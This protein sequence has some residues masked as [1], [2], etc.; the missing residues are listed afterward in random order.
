MIYTAKVI[1]NGGSQAIRLPKE[2]RTTR[3]EVYVQRVGSVMVIS[4]SDDPW[5]G[6][7]AAAGGIPGL[8]RPGV[9]SRA[10]RRRR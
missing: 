10:G 6:F 4:T 8:R 5:A 7:R 3:K 1:K 9:A 2:L